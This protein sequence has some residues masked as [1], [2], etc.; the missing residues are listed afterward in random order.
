MVNIKSYNDIINSIN[1][2]RKDLEIVR[3][4]LNEMQNMMYR[5]STEKEFK[6]WLRKHDP[7]HGTKYI[8]I[9][10]E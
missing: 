6:D 1:G 4:N 2:I 5:C 3:Q 10:G 8:M 7:E 9:F